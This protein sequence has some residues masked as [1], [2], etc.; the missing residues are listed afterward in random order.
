MEVIERGLHVMDTTALTLC[1]DND[2]PI[3]VFNMADERNVTRILTGERVGTV[4][5]N[6]EGGSI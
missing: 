5:A 4:V 6:D 3:M 2:L 1:M